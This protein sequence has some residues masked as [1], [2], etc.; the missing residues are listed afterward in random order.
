M[1]AKMALKALGSSQDDVDD[2]VLTAIARFLG[3]LSNQSV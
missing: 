3:E 2:G 1:V